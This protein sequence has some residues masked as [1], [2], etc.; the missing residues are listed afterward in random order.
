MSG[1][2]LLAAPPATA[3]VRRQSGVVRI[4]F[5][6]VIHASVGTDDDNRHNSNLG[7]HRT[8]KLAQHFL[9]KI[10]LASV[11]FMFRQVVRVI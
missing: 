6:E 3:C 10:I 4:L 2:C 1:A 5:P 11:V 8:L 7:P 9:Y